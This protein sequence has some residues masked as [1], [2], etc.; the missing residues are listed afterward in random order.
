M[1]VLVSVQQHNH[2]AGVCWLVSIRFVELGALTCQTWLGVQE[3]GRELQL[4]PQERVAA[5]RPFWETLTQE[6]RVQLLSIDLQDLHAR[7]KDVAARQRKQAGEEK[8]P[9]A[10]ME[11]PAPLASWVPAPLS[12]SHLGC[13]LPALRMHCMIRTAW[14]LSRLLPEHSSASCCWFT[15]VLVET[16]SATCDSAEQGKP[17]VLALMREP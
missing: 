14:L 5:V 6:Q 2:A 3:D 11:H 4:P 9:S 1:C 10:W 17:I 7:A 12:T 16:D 15:C 8:T 13:N